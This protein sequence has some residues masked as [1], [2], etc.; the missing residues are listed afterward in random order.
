[1][2]TMHEVLDSTPSTS[3]KNKTKQSKTKMTIKMEE[4]NG[5][6]VFIVETVNFLQLSQKKIILRLSESL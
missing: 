4:N 5:L 1:M 2:L 6:I 3:I